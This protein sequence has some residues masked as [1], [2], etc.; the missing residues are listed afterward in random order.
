VTPE[1]SERRA[2][3]ELQLELHARA[4]GRQPIITADD[5]LE[6][7]QKLATHEGDLR[8]LLADAA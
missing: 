5:L 4:N 6:L 3:F 7:H 1:S 8:S 2:L